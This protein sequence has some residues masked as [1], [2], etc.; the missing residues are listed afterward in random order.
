MSSM[1]SSGYMTSQSARLSLGR[2]PD[3]QYV[4]SG[5]GTIVAVSDAFLASRVRST[6]LDTALIM[7]LSVMS[8]FVSL[9]Q[10]E[11]LQRSTYGEAYSISRSSRHVSSPHEDAPVRKN[12]Y[13][14]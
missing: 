10:L 9:G 12:G 4:N 8:A 1:V 5:I 6:E 13:A 2:R 14:W 7:L 3:S 11:L